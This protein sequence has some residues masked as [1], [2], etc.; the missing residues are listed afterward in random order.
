MVLTAISININN[1]YIR[2]D[3]DNYYLSKDINNTKIFVF[4][5]KQPYLF[6]DNILLRFSEA[7][8]TRDTA[9]TLNGRTQCDEDDYG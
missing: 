3:T 5:Q 4:I 1:R 2:I 7:I 6:D 9:V 8:N